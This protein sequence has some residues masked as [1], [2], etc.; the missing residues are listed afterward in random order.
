M[1]KMV[2]FA[3]AHTFLIDNSSGY[4]SSK[5]S[6]MAIYMTYIYIDLFK[7]YNYLI[8]KCVEY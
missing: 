3:E 8:C 7:N 1:G 6:G 2:N 4:V 5:V